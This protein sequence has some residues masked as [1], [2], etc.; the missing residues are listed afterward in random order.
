MLGAGFKIAMR[1]MEIRG[2][3]NILGPEQSGHIATV[4][5]DMYCR[6]LEE[7]TTQ[8]KREPAPHRPSVHLELGITVHLPQRYIPSDRHRIEAYRRIARAPDFAA[9][10][11]VA[12]DLTD[13]YGPLPET[14]QRLLD[15]AEIRIGLSMLSV[16]AL[17]LTPPDLVFATHQV[18]PVFA[19]FEKTPGS[20]RLIDP[21]TSDRAGTI[22]WRPPE[23]YLDTGTLPA[24]LRKL[25]VRPLREQAAA[26]SRSATTA[27]HRG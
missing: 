24:V 4:G 3:G 13:A 19:L 10:D 14:A 18:K 27:G 20:V 21:P 7:E 15:L 17:K 1:D 9:L 26:T 6:L 2:V 16:E 23:A 22:F 11:Q 25:I 12:K 5:Y 8:L